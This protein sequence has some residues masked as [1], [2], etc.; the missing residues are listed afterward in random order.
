MNFIDFIHSNQ[1]YF[2]DFITR[3][4]HHSNGLEGNT[5]SM[6]DTYSIIFNRPDVVITASPREIYEAINLKYAIDT[7]T[8]LTHPIREQ[9]IIQLAIQINKN[10]SEISGYRKTQ[11]FIQGAEHIPLSPF[12]VQ[13][14]MMYFMEHY[15][16]MS[17]SSVFHK[18]A[19]M[20]IEF[21]RIHPFADGNGRAG[22]LLIWHE[23]I[24]NN[25]PPAIIQKNSKQEYLNLLEIQDSIALADFLQTLSETEAQRIQQF[26][27]HEPKGDTT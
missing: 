24:H 14:R 13:Q 9:D 12:Q 20:H 22:R 1:A 21:E 4:T 19:E 18:V 5:L 23:M 3:A 10:I 27:S 16:N 25:I 6:A 7:I 2:E 17:F 8:K 11:V 26:A 15:H